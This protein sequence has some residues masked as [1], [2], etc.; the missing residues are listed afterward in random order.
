MRPCLLFLSGASALAG[1]SFA[2]GPFD[3]RAALVCGV[4]FLTYGFGQA[5]TD[6]FQTDTDALSA[7]SRPLVRGL[8]TR[9]A[10]GMTSTVLLA[11]CGVTLGLMNPR[12]PPA[13]DL[14]GE[15]PRRPAAVLRAK[16]ERT[17]WVPAADRFRAGIPGS[18]G[19]TQGR[20][21][22]RIEEAGRRVARGVQNP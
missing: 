15:E 6:V 9:R 20:E 22:K 13:H 21:A 5:L 12:A 2:P 1:A 10:V 4:L 14:R 3:P 18:A 19:D 16:G 7:P 11:A 8:V 17:T